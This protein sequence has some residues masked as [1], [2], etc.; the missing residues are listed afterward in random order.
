[1]SEQLLAY[2]IQS[3]GLGDNDNLKSDDNP[4]D[5]WNDALSRRHSVWDD[6]KE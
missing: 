5:A 1:M 4:G 6:D 2:S 3:T